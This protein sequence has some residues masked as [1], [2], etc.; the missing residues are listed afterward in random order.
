MAQDL[1]DDGG[2]DLQGRRGLGEGG[3]GLGEEDRVALA[4]GDGDRPLEMRRQRL[5][6]RARNGAA[7]ERVLDDAVGALDRPDLAAE[8]RDLGHLDAAIV[9]EDRVSDWPNAA[10][11]SWSSWFF[12]RV[13]LPWLSS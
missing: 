5:E 10:V 6:R 9:D 2:L 13:R 8:L 7:G 3:Q 11:S 12:L 1:R 4:V